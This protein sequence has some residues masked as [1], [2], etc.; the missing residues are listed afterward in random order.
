MVTLLVLSVLCGSFG[1]GLGIIL[2]YFVGRRAEARRR[3]VGFPV[4]PVDPQR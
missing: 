3:Q 4:S 2:G 1:L